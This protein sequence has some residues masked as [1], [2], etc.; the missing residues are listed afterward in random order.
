MG[1]L[2]VFRVDHVPGTWG[3]ESN[4]SNKFTIVCLKG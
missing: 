3:G 1:V 2:W 4:L